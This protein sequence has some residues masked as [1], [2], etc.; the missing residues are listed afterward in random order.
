MRGGQIIQT[1]TLK[2]GREAI[3]RIPRWE[4]LDDLMDFINQLVKEDA[5]IIRERKVSRI[6]EAEWLAGQLIMLEKSELIHFVVEID[7]KVVASAEIK[8]RSGRQKHVGV[9]GIAVKFGYRRLGIATKLMETL[10]Q[11]AKKH[12][13]KVIILDVYE[14]NLPALGL[15][16][17]MGFKEVGRIP[18]AVFWKGEYIDDIKMAL[19]LEG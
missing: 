9:L 2:D 7:G 16:R 3:I 8:K 1:F 4:D 18:K 17:K 19:I 10:L 6:E 15:Y 12:G 14:K 11:E 5:P 13:L